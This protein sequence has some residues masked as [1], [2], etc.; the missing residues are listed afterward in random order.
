MS[1]TILKHQVT[2]YILKSS[3]DQFGKLLNKNKKLLDDDIIVTGKTFV[4]LIELGRKINLEIDKSDCGLRVIFNTYSE[5]DEE[6]L[7]NNYV[8]PKLKSIEFDE[9]QNI[10]QQKWVVDTIRFSSYAKFKNLVLDPYVKKL[11]ENYPL[12]KYIEPLLSKEKKIDIIEPDKNFCYILHQLNEL[13][14]IKFPTHPNGTND[15]KSI[16]RALEKAFNFSISTKSIGTYIGPEKIE[17]MKTKFDG[18][19]KTVARDSELIIPFKDRLH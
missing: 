5:N 7:K 10:C 2:D 11:N 9:F 19:I 1:R 17:T 16:A 8:E 15:L 4:D 14:Y 18:G 3:A 12:D 6:S 13:G